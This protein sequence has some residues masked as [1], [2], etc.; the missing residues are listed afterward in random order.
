MDEKRCAT[1]QYWYKNFLCDN[2]DGEYFNDFMF[3]HD[4]CPD[5]KEKP[6]S[7]KETCKNCAYGTERVEGGG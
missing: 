4:S 2:P 6:M 1:C 7:K 5:W 3:E